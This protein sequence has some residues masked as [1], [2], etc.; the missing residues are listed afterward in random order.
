[1]NPAYAPSMARKARQESC[2]QRVIDQSKEVRNLGSHGTVIG[3]DTND[4]MRAK[5][6]ISPRSEDP[7]P[8]LRYSD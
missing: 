1:M 5:L 4:V 3:L 7:K 6:L 2:G 8:H